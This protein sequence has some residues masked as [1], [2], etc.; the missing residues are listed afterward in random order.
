[1]KIYLITFDNY[2]GNCHFELYLDRKNALKR[3]QGLYK[4]G[5]KKAE[6]TYDIAPDEEWAYLSFFDPNYNHYSTSISM[7]TTNLE[8]LFY[9]EG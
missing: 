4:E 1:M 7:E 6:F 5:L 8:D 3:M 9:D 2:C